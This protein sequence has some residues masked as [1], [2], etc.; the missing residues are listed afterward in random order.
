MAGAGGGPPGV[1]PPQGAAVPM[2]VRPAGEHANGM[3]IMRAVLKA[4]REALTKL[5][6][7]KEGELVAEALVKLNKI[8]SRPEGGKEDSVD[9]HMRIAQAIA[10]NRR[11]QMP[12]PMPPGGMPP[13]APPPGMPP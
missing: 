1:L 3:D 9:P 5:G 8:F 11:T 7:S 6:P 4:M 13:G 12:P 2:A 10:E